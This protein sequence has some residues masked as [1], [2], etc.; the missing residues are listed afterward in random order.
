MFSQKLYGRRAMRRLTQVIAACRRARKHDDGPP[1]EDHG[2]FQLAVP[3]HLKEAAQRLEAAAYRID[4]AREQ[5]LTPE[6][7]REWLE[8]LTEFCLALSDV[9]E[10][11][12]ESIHEKLHELAGTLG[13]ED[14]LLSGKPSRKPSGK[15]GS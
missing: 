15:P 1:T 13:P 10:F 11:S 3:E 14:L 5:P 8:G 4:Q 9:Q 2:G 6:S 7:Q 12:N